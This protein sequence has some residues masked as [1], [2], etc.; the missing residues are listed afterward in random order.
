M[1]KKILILICAKGKSSEVKN[2][3]LVK[4]KKKT[5][6]EH[7]IDHAKKLKKSLNG[8]VMIIVSTDSKKIANIAKKSGVLIPFMRPSNLS[9]KTSPELNVWKHALLHLKQKKIFDPEIICS[10]S[11]TSP[12]RQTKDVIK[13]FRKFDNNNYDLVLTAHKSKNN[14]Y[15]NMLERNKKGKFVVPKTIHK[16]IFVRQKS[17][18]VYSINTVAYVAKV[19]F[20][21]KTKNLLNGKLG[22]Q[23]IEERYSLDIDSNYDVKI[24][25]LLQ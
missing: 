25:K 24:M 18:K 5:L 6:V 7:S 20:I 19:P 21:I 23:E 12:L 10:L 2:K 4:F 3:N 11:P 14:P 16:Q 22:V 17:P 1:S 13:C 15:F 9:N 8:E